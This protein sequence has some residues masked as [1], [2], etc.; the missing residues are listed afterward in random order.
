MDLTV[1]F[2]GVDDKLKLRRGAEG[3]IETPQRTILQ[4]PADSR[5]SYTVR[6]QEIHAPPM[7]L[8][9]DFGGVDDKLKL[10]RGAEGKI[11]TPHRFL[12]FLL[13]MAIRALDFEP[14]PT[15]TTSRTAISFLPFF[16]FEFAH[17]G[18]TRKFKNRLKGLVLAYSRGAMGIVLVYDVTNESSS[19]NSNNFL[20]LSFSYLHCFK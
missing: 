3:K 16:F 5:D 8:T 19:F 13:P 11:E 17:R 18:W 14:D 15:P 12:E 9:V 20:H 2:G 10:R 1:D 6:H 7:D 4:D